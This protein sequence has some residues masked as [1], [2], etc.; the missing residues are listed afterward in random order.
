MNKK[1][2]L[3]A[4]KRIWKYV[5][6]QWRRVVA[7]FIL[8]ILIATMFTTT[9][10]TILPTLKVMMGN[11]GLHGWIDR[12]ISSHRY[13][14]KFYVP[15][16]TDYQNDDSEGGINHYLLITKVNKDGWADNAGLKSQDRIIGVGDKLC[17]DT[18]DIA[19]TKLLEELATTKNIDSLTI[20]FLRT[21][22]LG[23]T[24]K[25]EIK[26]EPPKY[27]SYYD[28]IQWPA[29]FLP[30]NETKSIKYKAIIIIAIVMLVLTLF[31]CIARFYQTYLADKIMNIA[32]GQLRD[33]LFEHIVNMPV[34][35]FSS[36][37]TSDTT[38]RL[39]N[40]IAQCGKG[41]KVLLGKTIREPIKAASCLA[42]ALLINW[43]MTLIFI[44]AAP[45]T[46]A[47]FGI[48]GKRIKKASKRSLQSTSR[49]LGL[50]QGA[51]AALRV[52]KVYNRQEHEIQ[53]YKEANKILVKRLLKVARIE[54]LTN[55]LLEVLGMIACAASLI[56]GASWVAKG[57]IEPSEFFVLLFF[58]GTAAESTRRVSGVWNS[59]QS[60]NAA[61]E[62][63]FEIIDYPLEHE[64]PDAFELEPMKEEIAFKD[65][66]FTYPGAQSPALRNLNLKVKAGQ[67]IAIVGSNGSGKSTLINLIPRFY[68][69]DSGQI[70]IDG[71]DI[72]KATAKSLRSQIG[73]VTQG[74]ITFNDTVANNISY[75]KPD[76]T[77][78]EIIEASKKA[79]AHEF[80]ET[81]PDGYDTMIG[82]HSS[83]FSGGQL[84]RI[85][86]ARAILKNPAILIFDEAMSQ[87]DADSE[88]KIH[89][90]L[91]EIMK[92][93]TCFLIAHRF[94]TVISADSI[95]VIDAGE[96]IAQGTHDELAEN[97]PIYK[98][99]YETQ[100][101]K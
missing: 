68:D 6:V 56:F 21:N 44:A 43:Q 1:D 64:E 13:D 16:I 54:R 88:M 53:S 67:T 28:A 19:S 2:D 69:P 79:F 27:H 71:K 20:Q 72:H 83:G 82:E 63:V 37:G 90:A 39:I 15:D 14:M 47:A 91:S 77:M 9:F 86:I 80:I 52:I 7:V 96:V 10:M 85:V 98:R 75:S 31:R 36:K 25:K 18:P 76:A 11:E 70:T 33:D 101:L 23:E 65:I 4:F 58:L 59:I 57:N 45:L 51:M 32:V 3:A 40:D 100:L 66:T 8:S 22:S 94:S 42:T 48:L 99:L 30:R 5:W 84:Q 12:K 24:E 35:F 60:A 95:A 93:R 29:S 78:E 87:I 26:L 46:I 49:M 97:C 74:I 38:S 61:A 55:P 34:G 89:N 17:K 92:G 81:L 41:I 50:I 62:R 73:M